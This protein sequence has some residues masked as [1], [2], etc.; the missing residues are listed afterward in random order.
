LYI[1]IYL[2]DRGYF[3]S[4]YVLVY[5][6]NVNIFSAQVWNIKVLRKHLL[7]S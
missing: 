1:N 2:H 5:C 4:V 7:R 3:I 6:I